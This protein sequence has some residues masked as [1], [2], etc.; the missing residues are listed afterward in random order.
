MRTHQWCAGLLALPILLGGCAAADG[1]TQAG[2]Q[3][4][5][6]SS[7]VDGGV[8]RAS[9]VADVPPPATAEMVCGAEISGKVAQVLSL[10]SPAATRT[11]WVDNLYTCT[12]Q[13]PMGPLIL[14]VKASPSTA[15]AGEYFDARRLEL[16]G[17]TPALGLGERA[18]ATPAGTVVGI[19]DAMTLTVDATGLPEVFGD[20]GQKRTDLAHE[21]ASDV[22]GCWTGGE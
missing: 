18:Y 20:N 19:K 22:L 21:V 1:A 13:L 5:N 7:V 8:P 16:G 2:A 10:P 11:S 12:H 4:G 6:A 14:S 17:T 9:G 3:P 15:A